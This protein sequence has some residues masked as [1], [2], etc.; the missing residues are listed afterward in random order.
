MNSLALRV[1][2]YAILAINF[3]LEDKIGKICNIQ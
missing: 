1:Y 3:N 2:V